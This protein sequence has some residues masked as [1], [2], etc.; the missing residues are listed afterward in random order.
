MNLTW[1][2]FGKMEHIFRSAIP[3][4]IKR[5]AFNQCILPMINYGAGTL[6]IT[7]TTMHKLQVA[8]N[9]ADNIKSYTA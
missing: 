6:T 4:S 3:V 8:E 5:K 9:G 1:T 7:R 2:A